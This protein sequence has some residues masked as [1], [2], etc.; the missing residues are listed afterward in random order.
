MNEICKNQLNDSQNTEV[1]NEYVYNRHQSII[2]SQ[3]F[4][5]EIISF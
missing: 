5:L 3:L 2:K 4:D 1:I